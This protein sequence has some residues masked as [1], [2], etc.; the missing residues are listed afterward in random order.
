MIARKRAPTVGMNKL[1]EFL[2]YGAVLETGLDLSDY[3]VEGVG[4]YCVK[5][6]E[7]SD[8]ESRV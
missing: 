4:C 3:L 8:Y 5:L 7:C 6:S 2:V 1:R